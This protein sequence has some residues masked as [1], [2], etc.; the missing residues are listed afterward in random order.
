MSEMAKGLSLRPQDSGSH[1][2]SHAAVL[3][4]LA[5]ANETGPA[6]HV[7]PPK[8]NQNLGEMGTQAKEEFG[9]LERVSRVNA[10]KLLHNMMTVYIQGID[11]AFASRGG[12][13]Y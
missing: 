13:A 7:E 4:N 11:P 2:H 9:E 1:S 5:K 6:E 12:S 3:F 10:L 8:S